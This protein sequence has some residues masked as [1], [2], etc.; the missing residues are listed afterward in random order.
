MKEKQRQ[1]KEREKGKIKGHMTQS[2]RFLIEKSLNEGK[3][4]KETAQAVGKSQTTISREVKAHFIEMKKGSAFGKFNDCGNKGGCR[5]SR[6]CGPSAGACRHNCPNC[7]LRCRPGGCPRYVKS[8]CS[9]LE[10]PPYVCNGCPE[11]KK[12][13]TMTRNYYRAV[14]AQK[15]YETTLVE[16]RQGASISEQEAREHAE[17]IRPLLKNHQS[18]YNILLACPEITYSEKTMYNYIE[19]GVYPEIGNYSLPRKIRYKPRKRKRAIPVKV[20][21]KC[22]IGRGWDDYNRYM[23]SHPDVHVV[24]MDCVEGLR[25]EPKTLLT[26]HLRDIRFQLAIV[27]ERKTSENVAA[28]FSRLRQFLNEDFR[29]IF[30]LILTDNGTE[31]SDP[32]SIEETSDGEITTLVFYCQ[33]YSFTQKGA[34]EKNHEEIRCILPKNKSIQHVTQ[35]DMNLVMSHVNS[36]ARASLG[37]RTPYEKF[38]ERFGEQPLKKLGIRFIP[39][40]DVNLTPN[41]IK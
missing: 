23:E 32:R 7:A 35:E 28:A 39:A 41:L 22:T 27:L 14:E 25:N 37:G 38:V 13:C 5:E 31:F 40:K 21:R 6:L 4:F 3:N 2:D 16:S 8:T 15:E 29:R 12:R 26:L 11:D 9:R 24:E 10:R 19:Q 20:D 17:M 33:P 36:L 30:R 1:R 34:C 18:V